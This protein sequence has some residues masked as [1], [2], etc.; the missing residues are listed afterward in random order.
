MRVAVD[1]HVEAPPERVWAVLVDWEAQPRWMVDA[2]AVEVIGDRREGVGTRLRCPTDLVGGLV[3][4]DEF[5]VVE[6]KPPRVLGVLH[7]GWLIRGV[8][9]FELTATDHGTHVRWWEEIV[10]PLGSLGELAAPLV[11]PLVARVFRRSLAGL[12]RAVEHRSVRPGPNG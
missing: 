10:P 8:G 2:R 7:T 9:A 12:K 3:V 1:I 5:E 4:V 11:E 6:W